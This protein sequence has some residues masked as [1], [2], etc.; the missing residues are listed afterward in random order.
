MQ[1]LFYVFCLPT[2]N[3]GRYDFR[4][5][6]VVVTGCGR[7]RLQPRRVDGR[8][9]VDGD[10]PAWDWEARAPAGEVLGVMRGGIDG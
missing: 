5:A 2:H 7:R 1:L 6:F 3:V 10:G 4:P 8:D 9:V